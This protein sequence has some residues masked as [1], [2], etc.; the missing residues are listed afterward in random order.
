MGQ[1]G[2][3]A[4]VSASDGQSGLASDPSGSVPIST[5][6]TGP[7]TVTRTAVDSVGHETTRSCTTQVTQSPPELGRCERLKGE[8]VGGETVYHGSYR[9]SKCKTPQTGGEYEWHSGAASTAVTTSGSS[10]KLETAGGAA[11]ARPGGRADR[12]RGPLG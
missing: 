6:H 11:I 7:E 2:V 12:R 5:A 9:N 3:T 4:T 1:Q 10:I 8:E